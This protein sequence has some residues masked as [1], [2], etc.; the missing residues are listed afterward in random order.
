MRILFNC[1]VSIV[2]GEVKSAEN[3]IG[4][5]NLSS[6]HDFLFYKSVKNF[7]DVPSI[8]EPYKTFWID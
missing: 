8:V 7:V 3:F 5:V 1:F 2:S 4:Y 6:G